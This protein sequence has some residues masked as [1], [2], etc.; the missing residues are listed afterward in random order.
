MSYMH[1]RPDA[2]EGFDHATSGTTHL[3]TWDNTIP[4]PRTRGES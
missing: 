1:G 4:K 2:P 3:F